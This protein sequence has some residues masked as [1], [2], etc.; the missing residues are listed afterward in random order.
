MANDEDSLNDQIRAAL[1]EAKAASVRLGAVLTE[2]CHRRERAE[3]ERD[4]LRAELDR[5][6]KERDGLKAEVDQWRA[7]H[8]ASP[9]EGEV[10]T[11]ACRHTRSVKLIEGRV[12]LDCRKEL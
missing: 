4:T 11:P 1:A 12:C 3:S 9:G 7:A 2:E 6:T 8:D 10:S 5:V